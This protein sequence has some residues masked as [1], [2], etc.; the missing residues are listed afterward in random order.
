[1]MRDSFTNK[2]Q[3][4]NKERVSVHKTKDKNQPPI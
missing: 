1:M 3:G 4:A 2:R